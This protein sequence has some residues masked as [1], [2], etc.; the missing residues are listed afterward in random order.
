MIEMLDFL[1]EHAVYYEH[2]TTTNST[3]NVHIFNGRWF[4]DSKNYWM[5]LY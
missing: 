1:H 5:P 2:F 3:F 4:T